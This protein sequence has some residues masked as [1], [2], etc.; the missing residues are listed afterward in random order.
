MFEVVLHRNPRSGGWVATAGESVGSGNSPIE[1]LRCLYTLAPSD[2][3]A[4]AGLE[5][6]PYL[7]ALAQFGTARP[8]P[9]KAKRKSKREQIEEA[10]QMALG[11]T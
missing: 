9:V 5:A 8:A 6:K 7:E 3:L 2:E 11:E 10:G 1:A 4:R